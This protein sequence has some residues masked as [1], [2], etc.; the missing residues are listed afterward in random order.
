MVSKQP[1]NENYFW[2]GS[3]VPVIT[4]I[5]NESDDL[6]KMV[7]LFKLRGWVRLLACIGA[8]ICFLLQ[9]A[10]LGMY[11][12]Y[13]DYQISFPM[14]IPSLLILVLL[15]YFYLPF[16]F[17]CKKISNDIFWLIEEN[18]YLKGDGKI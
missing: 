4:I 7:V 18:L 8:L 9:F 14:F 3:C 10:I 11:F 1:K 6:T 16:I 17:S 15:I 12:T 5:M 13:G 2:K